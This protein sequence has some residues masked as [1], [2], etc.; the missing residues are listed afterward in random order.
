MPDEEYKHWLSEQ[1][2]IAEAEQK[3]RQ[4]SDF[5]D[6]IARFGIDAANGRAE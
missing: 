4:Q 6:L 2:Q 5:N 3:A 1:L